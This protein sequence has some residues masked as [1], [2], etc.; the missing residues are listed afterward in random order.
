MSTWPFNIVGE[1][2]DMVPGRVLTENG[3]LATALLA[4]TPIG[5]KGWDTGTGVDVDRPGGP[6]WNGCWIPGAVVDVTGAATFWIGNSGWGCAKEA[7][8]GGTGTAGGGYQGWGR[9][10]TGQ[11]GGWIPIW[12]GL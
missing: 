4:L 11:V 6:T 8:T 9:P 10:A 12:A 5:N 2:D 7:G 1:L 3:E